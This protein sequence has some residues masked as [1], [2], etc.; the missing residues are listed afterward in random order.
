MI[1]T[2][3]IKALNEEA[4]I[5]DALASALA[6]VEPF[7]GEV[8]LA[9]C[10]SADRTIEVARNFPV[11][12]VQL[13]ASEPPSCGAGAQLAYQHARGQFFYLLDGDQVL[14]PGFL[15]AAIAYLEAHPD[16]AGVGGLIQ[17]GNTQGPEFELR[18]KSARD[19]AAADAGIVD[20]LDC[21][22]LYRT[23]AIREVGYFADRN[24]HSFEE[25]DV[26][27]RL[28]ARG[29]KLA[30]IHLPA[31][32]HF[33]HTDGGYRLLWR[34]LASGYAGGVGEV[35][36]AAL[37]RDHLGIVLRRL[38]HVRNSALVI[39]WWLLIAAFAIA[40]RPLAVAA[41]LLAP[42]LFL[43][44]RRGSLRLGL[45]SLA[46]WNVTALG[47]LTGLFV[48]RLPAQRPLRS[49]ELSAP[50]APQR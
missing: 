29:W 37:G 21:G 18:A 11:R 32:D 42:L 2:V 27:A 26:A 4:R 8:V 45:Y 24:L 41:L 14:R 43:S 3:G 12:I 44:V 50:A 31:A 15:P 17:E 13:E 39:C 40:G 16:V 7:D 5:A 25:F 10:G 47:L 35:L 36:R 19:D 9:D 49:I 1:I 46:S 48:R 23:S 6:A 28:Q 33:G 30:R 34:R 20:R 22:G 38:S